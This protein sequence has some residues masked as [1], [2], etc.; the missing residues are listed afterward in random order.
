MYSSLCH[1]VLLFLDSSVACRRSQT[2]HSTWA[3]RGW[4]RLERMARE[5]ARDDGY[6]IEVKSALHLSFVWNMYRKGTWPRTFQFWSWSL[7]SEASTWAHGLGHYTICSSRRWQFTQK[8][9]VS[10]IKPG[11]IRFMYWFTP[12][13][14]LTVPKVS[15]LP[16]FSQLS[17][18]LEH[19]PLAVWWY[20]RSE[21]G[22]GFGASFLYWDWSFNRSSVLCCGTFL[23][24]TASRRCWSVMLVGLPL[25]YAVVKGDAFLMRV[26]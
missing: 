8:S 2:R 23:T 4:C 20:S 26:M 11:N 12:P 13:S 5:M 18:S 15:A 6:I 25:C 17:L 24:K 16:G 3:S 19:A 22:W 21:S 14:T 7:T 1:K 10:T 9:F